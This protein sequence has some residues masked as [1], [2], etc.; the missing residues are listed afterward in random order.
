MFYIHELHHH[1]LRSWKKLQNELP[2]VI[3][4]DHHTDILPAFMRFCQ[5]AEYPPDAAKNIEE[6]IKLLRHDEHFDYALKYNIISSA[7]IISHSPAVTEHSAKLHVCYNGG[8]TDDEP[9]NSEKYKNYFDKALEDDFLA[10]FNSF[11]PEKNYILDIDC[12]YF[13]T[14]LSLKPSS[15]RIFKKLVRNASMITVSREDDWIKLLT[16]EN[17][18]SFNSDHIIASLEKLIKTQK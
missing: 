15:C 17:P 1:V 9:L 14:A 10:E 18:Q 2:S 16:F 5:N 4:F 13:K 7:V 11:L 6:D 3:S 12:D 8:F